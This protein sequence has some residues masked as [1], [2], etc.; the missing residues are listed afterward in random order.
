[1]RKSSSEGL[2]GISSF[3][4]MPITAA[5]ANL[6]LTWMWCQRVCNVLYTAPWNHDNTISVGSW[7]RKA[8][9]FFLSILLQKLDKYSR[10]L[11]GNI[12]QDYP[13]S[14]VQVVFR[15]TYGSRFILRVKKPRDVA[16]PPPISSYFKQVTHE[17]SSCANVSRRSCGMTFWCLLSLPIGLRALLCI[18]SWL[19]GAKTF[20]NSASVIK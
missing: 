5:C 17:L 11:I 4:N 1:M 14:D 6:S 3:A 12:M 13:R 18:C 8:A 20:T 19:H 7:T 10:R 9:L 15:Y 2:R 16:T